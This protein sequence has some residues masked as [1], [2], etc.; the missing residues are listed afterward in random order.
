M[1][2]GTQTNPTSPGECAPYAIVLDDDQSLAAVLARVVGSFGYDVGVAGSIGQARKLIAS[3]EPA[4]MLLDEALPDGD[5]LEFMAEIQARR[6]LNFVVI[7]DDPSQQLAVKCIRARAFDLLPKTVGVD[8]LKRTIARAGD[9]NDE[10]GANQVTRSADLALRVDLSSIS[11][12]DG[13]ESEALRL[14]IRQAASSGNDAVVIEGDAGTEKNAIAEAIHVQSHRPGR[15]ITVNCRAECDDGAPVRFFGRR[16]A[17]GGSVQAGY[18]EQ[19]Q[20][21]SLVLDDIAAL[22][23]DMQ[24]RLIPFLDQGQFLP[25]GGAKPIKAR[26]SVIAIVRGQTARALESETLLGD[27]HARL[28]KFSFTAPTLKQRAD[29]ALAIAEHFLREQ[30]ERNGT[31]KYLSE[32]A[33]A[34]ITEH[35]WPGNVRELKNALYRAVLESEA[36]ARLEIRG[37]NEYLVEASENSA[38]SGFI[39]STFWQIEKELLLATLE[40][41][42]GDKESTARMLGI[43]LK[44]LY[45]RLHAYS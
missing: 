43:S 17:N 32:H 41:N 19:A 6:R 44:T 10:F 23:S 12:G 27:L 8:D 24:S 9:L 1:T 26:V 14:R 30:N 2:T 42:D 21:G 39:G 3:R 25:E 40:H 33:R 35:D 4:M 29:D 15:L 18:L 28:A 34:V 31:A 16:D 36:S 20:G 7:A 37:L 22:P 13:N 38:I 11:V 45:N 5:G